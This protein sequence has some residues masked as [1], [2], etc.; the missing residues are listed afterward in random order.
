VALGLAAGGLAILL[1]ESSLPDERLEDIGGLTWREA[2]VIG[3]FQCFALWPGISRAA[4]TILGGMLVGLRRKAAAEYSFLAAVPAL[5]AAGL[6][7]LA[8]S[9]SFL[10]A[11]DVPL[12]AVGF[13]VAFG[14]ALLA[15]R[16]FLHLL[17][18]GTLRPFGWYRLVLALAVI[19]LGV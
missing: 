10:S 7:D 14:A 6:Y 8:R 2:L 5:F 15:I 13:G 1:M 18:T 9:L 12:F 19:L 3:L 11:A 4:T 16:F 17:G